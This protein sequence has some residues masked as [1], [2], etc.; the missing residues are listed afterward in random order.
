MSD[1]VNHILC[2]RCDV[3]LMDV[4]ILEKDA[5][6]DWNFIVH[7]DYCGGKSTEHTFHGLIQVASTEW[8]DHTDYVPDEDDIYFNVYTKKVTGVK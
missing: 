6:A 8:V 7:C 2:D 4:I 5:D 1:K 3:G